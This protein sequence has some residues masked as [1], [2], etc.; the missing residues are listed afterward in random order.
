MHATLTPTPT[1]TPTPAV[2][3]RR[4]RSSDLADLALSDLCALA[5][6]GNDD[7]FVEITRR[8]GSLI[9]RCAQDCRLDK[10]TADDLA[11]DTW[12]MLFKYLPSI[13]TPEALPG[14]IRTTAQRRAWAIRTRGAVDV[15]RFAQQ[16]PQAQF[17]GPEEAA[18]EAEESTEV[19]RAFRKL[20]ARDQAVLGLTVMSQPAPAYTEVAKSLGCAVGSIG[21]FRS[22]SL[23]RLDRILTASAH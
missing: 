6:D 15:D 10:A 3:S 1:P 22:R 14:W 9:N 16:A 7:A 4:P 19:R 13:R 11:Q 12:L 8:F 20:P 18:I 23:D 2:R 5:L 17:V 21:P